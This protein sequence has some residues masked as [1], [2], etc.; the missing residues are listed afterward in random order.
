MWK[1]SCGFCGR[2]FC[3]VDVCG[4]WNKLFGPVLSLLLLSW[5]EPATPSCSSSLTLC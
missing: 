4:S 3:S 1:R 2:S 5:L